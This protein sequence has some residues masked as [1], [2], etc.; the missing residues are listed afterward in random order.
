MNNFRRSSSPVSTLIQAF[1]ELILPPNP[2]LLLPPS[3]Y[4]LRP[5]TNPS[6]ST[7]IRP[8]MVPGHGSSGL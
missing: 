7:R 8:G 1:V 4:P 6:P 3:Y 2:P 5:A